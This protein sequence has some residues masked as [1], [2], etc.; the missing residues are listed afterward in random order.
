MQYAKKRLISVNK[1]R[2]K[3]FPSLT[4]IKINIKIINYNIKILILR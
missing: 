2:K 1:K 3:D 4:F